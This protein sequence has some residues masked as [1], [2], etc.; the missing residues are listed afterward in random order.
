[1]RSHAFSEDY[2]ILQGLVATRP[3][4]AAEEGGDDSAT[5]V[6]D[7][8]APQPPLNYITMMVAKHVGKERAETLS[9]SEK[10]NIFGGLSAV[11][12]HIDK[13]ACKGSTAIPRSQ[14]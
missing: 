8:P 1:M 3:S 10:L 9:V 7:N 12:H 5:P 4:S 11:V 2:T 13:L 6:D 14:I